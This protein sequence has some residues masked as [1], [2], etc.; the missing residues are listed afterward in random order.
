MLIK[1]GTTVPAK[2]KSIQQK[3]EQ[4][5]FERYGVKC[6]LQL[7]SVQ[8]DSRIAL[9]IK[10]YNEFIMTDEFDAPMFSLE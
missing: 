7:T 2:N 4:T 9:K 1:Y 10:S 6:A 5:M 3:I 8:N